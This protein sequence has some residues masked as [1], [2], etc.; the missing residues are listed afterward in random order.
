[1]RGPAASWVRGAAAARRWL[2][3]RCGA[4]LPFAGLGAWLPIVL[5]AVAAAA[6]YESRERQWA[7][8]QAHPEEFSFSAGPLVSTFDAGSFLFLA[9]G[10]QGDG[11]E[12]RT[13]LEVP[14]LSHAIRISAGAFYGG[15]LL[16]AGN[17]MIPWSA[18][19]TAVTVALCFTALGFA[20][21]GAVAGLSAAVAAAV[22][23]RTAIGR[24]DT[25]Q[26][27]VAF[28]YLTLAC[29][30]LA[31]RTGRL[32]GVL[33]ASALAGLT[34]FFFWWW[35]GG[36]G[37]TVVFLAVLALTVF[38]ARRRV[39]TVALACLLFLVFS[40]PQVLDMTHHLGHFVR[41]YVVGSSSA[42]PPANSTGGADGLRL[43]EL[44]TVVSE[45]RSVDLPTML[46]GISGEDTG[47]LAVIGAVGLVAFAL[48]HPRRILPVL[49][50]IAFATLG[51][52]KGMRF[53]MYAV[54]LFWFGLAFLASSSALA[55]LNAT[56]QSRSE[57]ARACAVCAVMALLLA[58]C[59]RTSPSVC[60]E[61]PA[62]RCTPLIVPEVAVSAEISDGFLRLRDLQPE[63]DAT[64]ATHWNYAHWLRALT[65]MKP[66]TTPGLP[67]DVPSHLVAR[68][69]T[70]AD[71][72][73]AAEILRYLATTPP[74]EIRK[75]ARSRQRL[76]AGI[77]SAAAPSK[78]LY[79]VVTREML[80]WWQ[81]IS[82]M[83]SWDAGRPEGPAGSFR[84]A[85]CRFASQQR[86]DCRRFSLDVETGLTSKGARLAALVLTDRG[87]PT[88][89]RRYAADG[90]WVMIVDR[91]G[92][93]RLQTT[94]MES[95]L[96]ETLFARLY[97]LGQPDPGGSDSGTFR[98]V[99]DGFPHYRI[100]QVREP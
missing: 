81:G 34:N 4:P 39:G 100:F 1:M 32:W 73:S 10:I 55:V 12:D 29:V 75:D 13:L 56:A 33:A 54:P 60:R 69:L 68:A 62:D 70:A 3:A 91:S 19:I 98:L 74:S 87:R 6:A 9:G 64:V 52:F 57:R 84:S 47:F 66:A 65:G 63:G 42:S 17:R 20:A 36:S 38:A 79:L 11:G 24:I 14:L 88:G 30:A 72:E 92:S 82:L 67:R 85:S 86:L 77:E 58:V 28:F 83:S 41:M 49:P 89:V 80:A 25:D 31:G 99:A 22:A 78:P 95:S 76:V 27:N 7:V 35:Y 44:A 90:S 46:R 43:P 71:Q 48:V 15:N 37:F 23:G 45:A 21:E 94:V 2:V 53:L 26:L 8:W 96:F 93:G 16:L 40:G 5:I 97:F 18:A 50:A 61:E 59:W 51:V